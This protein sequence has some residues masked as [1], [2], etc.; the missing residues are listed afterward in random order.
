[1]L[2]WFKAL[3]LRV[4]LQLPGMQHHCL[5]VGGRSGWRKWCS[6]PLLFL[7]CFVCFFNG[8]VPVVCYFPAAGAWLT[9]PQHCVLPCG[10]GRSVW[11][12][13]GPTAWVSIVVAAQWMSALG[14][15]SWHAAPAPLGLPPRKEEKRLLPHQCHLSHSL[16]CPNCVKNSTERSK[17][18]TGK[19]TKILFVLLDIEAPLLFY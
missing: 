11:D 15:E 16:G 3:L 18:S 5:S 17:F 4:A 19:L 12:A 6:P 10:K 1:M 7:P 2:W 14:A 13:Y 8:L 9:S